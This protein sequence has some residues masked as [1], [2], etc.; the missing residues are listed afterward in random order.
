VREHD[1]GKPM[2]TSLMA[3][4]RERTVINPSYFDARV[5]KPALR[6]AGV[7]VTRANGTHHGSVI[8]RAGHFAR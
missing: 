2:T 4:T 5:W 6:E 1:K 3:T 8:G 7:P